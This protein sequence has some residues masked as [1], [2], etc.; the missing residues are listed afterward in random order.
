[1]SMI[2]NA[3][4]RQMIEVGKTVTFL[5]KFVMAEGLDVN[6]RLVSYEAL[7]LDEAIDIKV[8]GQVFEKNQLLKLWLDRMPKDT[9]SK[10]RNAILRVTG[11]V[12]FYYH[13]VSAFI[14]PA[15]FEVQRVE[16]AG[17]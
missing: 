5:G 2:A 17:E 6:E 11:Q 12:D 3:G 9:F 14:N 1:M 15:K 10:N 4:D 8:D 7:K 13:G 16:Y